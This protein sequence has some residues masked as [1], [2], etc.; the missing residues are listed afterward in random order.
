[1]EQMKMSLDDIDRRIL[2]LI[3]EEFP[4]AERPFDELGRVAGVD[5]REALERVRALKQKGY[6]R[7]L[8]P[9]L[10]RKKLGYV[11]TLCGLHVDEDNILQVAG[12]INRQTG[13][14]HNY[15][16]EGELNLW[17]TITKKTDQEIDSFISHLEKTFAIKVYRFPE[18]QVFKI[19]TF[20]RV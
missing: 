10:E 20:F 13:V 2:N 14:T 12:E 18:K 19:K 5:G 17:F 15:E 8:G 11:S 16:R 7:R 6:I 3:Q 4:L 1:V 9:I